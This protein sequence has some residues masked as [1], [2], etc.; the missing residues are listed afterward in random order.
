MLPLAFA[1]LLETRFA[2]LDAGLATAAQSS[3]RPRECRATANGVDGLWRRLRGSDAERY[4]ELLARGFARLVETPN[5]ALSAA[6]AAEA[7]AGQTPAVR[8]LIGRASWRLGQ[9][10]LAYEQFLAAEA[11]GAAWFA[12]PKALHDYA[13]AASLVGQSASALRLFRLLASRVAL[14]DDARERTLAQ[15]E[16]AAHV[17]ADG[18]GGADEALGYLA[19]ARQQPLGLLGL[20]DALRGLALEQSGRPDP[21][22]GA[23]AWGSLALPAFNFTESVPLLPAGQPDTLRALQ[24]RQAEPV[25]SGRGR[26]R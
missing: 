5:Q 6:R 15:I 9:P 8:V 25:K 23:R 13:R 1:V 21:Q 16:A 22:R 2:S 3:P 7:L 12:D 4:C 26:A 20:I 19:H 14:L 10:R 11:S 24:S 17:L 18:P